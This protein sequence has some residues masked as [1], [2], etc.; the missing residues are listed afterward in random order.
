MCSSAETVTLAVEAL[1]LE[2]EQELEQEHESRSLQRVRV[3]HVY[4][5]CRQAYRDQYDGDG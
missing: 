3:G 1:A 5:C 2:L 4:R